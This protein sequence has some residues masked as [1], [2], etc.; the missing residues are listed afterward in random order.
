[1]EANDETWGWWTL[2]NWRSHTTWHLTSAGGRMEF[3]RENAQ[4]MCVCYTC[5]MADL[6]IQKAQLYTVVKTPTVSC[7]IAANNGIFNIQLT[8][9]ACTAASPRFEFVAWGF[10]AKVFICLTFY[11]VMAFSGP[12]NGTILKKLQNGVLHQ[13]NPIANLWKLPCFQHKL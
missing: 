2:S 6:R 10:Q 3:G 5:N 12:Q 7:A 4:G 13:T 9:L 11:S 8:Q 1:M